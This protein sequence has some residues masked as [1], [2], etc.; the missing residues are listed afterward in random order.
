[1][2]GRGERRSCKWGKWEAHRLQRRVERERPVGAARADESAGIG[3]V[4]HAGS[5]PLALAFADR[6]LTTRSRRPVKPTPPR[7]PVI[8]SRPPARRA[9]Y[10]LCRLLGRRPAAR[11]S[12]CSPWRADA[13]HA[14]DHPRA[15]PFNISNVTDALGQEAQRGLGR[16][17][18]CAA[19]AHHPHR[20]RGGGRRLRARVEEEKRKEKEAKAKASEGP[21]RERKEQRRLLRRGG[22]SDRQ[23]EA[24]SPPT[25]AREGLKPRPRERPERSARRNEARVAGCRG[26]S[27]RR[28]SRRPRRSSCK[29]EEEAP[30]AAR[31]RSG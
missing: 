24:K 15:V 26:R 20:R 14:A 13:G 1:M 3:S 21:S 27:R 8:C 10:F 23:R 4:R 5:S 19:E 9:G 22:G 31:R 12:A 7:A 25:E 2:G 6:R 30:S 16:G 11:S 28:R 18:R 17:Q 29:R